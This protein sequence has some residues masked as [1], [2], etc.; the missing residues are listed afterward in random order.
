MTAL[1]PLPT[2]KAEDWRY[3]DVDAVAKLWP[4]PEPVRITVAA[5]EN[6]AQQLLQQTPADAIS[7]HDYVI[8]IEEGA[9][10][11][12]HLLNMGGRLGRVT[13]DVTLQ[14]GARFDLNAA[15]IGG[16]EQTLEVVTK[17]T[18]AEPDAV[19]RQTVRSILGGNATGSYLGKVAVARGANGTD[20]QQSVKAMLVDRTATANAKPELEIF[21]D[22]VKC[23]HGATV[24]ELDQMALFYCAS[25]G[26]DPATARKLLLQ[27]FIAGL[28]DDIADEVQK[29]AFEEAA[30]ARLEALV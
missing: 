14:K 27:A 2:Q 26:L 8:E 15:L 6:A 1:A 13:F 18:H 28:F 4:L 7:V 23:A 16:G 5:G 11:D 10:L 9:G 3:S 17:V 20:A 29:A 21:A 24:G 22:D 30:L 25:R 12:F 19:S